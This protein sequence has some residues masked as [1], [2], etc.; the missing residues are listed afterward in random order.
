MQNFLTNQKMYLLLLTLLTLVLTLTAAL[1][2]CLPRLV[3]VRV[4]MS[5]GHPLKKALKA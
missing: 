1:V 4:S 2:Y 3:P 5:L